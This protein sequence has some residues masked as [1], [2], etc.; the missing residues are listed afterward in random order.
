[1]TLKSDARFEEKPICCFKNDMNLVNFSKICTLTGPF[2]AKYIT[3]D[4]KLY[5]EV[6][7][8]DI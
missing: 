6:V 8:H 1:M 3:F 5:R 4:L 7:F 2:S